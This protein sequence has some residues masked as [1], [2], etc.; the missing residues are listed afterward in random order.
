MPH[1]KLFEH[2]KIKKGAEDCSVEYR[3][4]TAIVRPLYFRRL[5]RFDERYSAKTGKK[6]FK[7]EQDQL[8]TKQWVGVFNVE[9]LSVEI[10]PKIERRTS[11]DGEESDERTDSNF[12]RRNLLKM[13]Q[14]AGEIP[15]RPRGMAN[16][17][18]QR[19]TI[20]EAFIQIFSERLLQE[21]KKGRHKTYVNESANLSKIRGKIDFSRQFTQNVA[22]HDRF[23]VN[24]EDFL[25]DNR[26]NQVFKKVCSSLKQRVRS[27]KTIERLNHILMMLGSVSRR[28]IT[29]QDFKRVHFTRQNDRFEELFN[30]CRLMFMGEAPTTASGET[31]SFALLFDMNHVYES[32]VAEYLRRYVLSRPEFQDWSIDTQSQNIGKYLLRR[33]VD[34][35]K[36]FIL[37]PDIILTESAKEDD[38]A[39]DSARIVIDTKWKRLGTKENG[40]LSNPNRGDLYQLYAY[41]HRYNSSRNILLYP[42]HDR[43]LKSESYIL[44]GTNDG[45][46][47]TKKVQ[48]NFLNMGLDFRREHDRLLNEF[49]RI[50]SP[51]RAS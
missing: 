29:A 50:L 25:P 27:S 36:S 9:G 48:L 17:A 37:R 33:E 2:Q 13:L 42:R 7:W 51:S 34:N 12:A 46:D 31:T 26:L 18:T 47:S 6:L 16:I 22:R 44:P 15:S 1:L 39:V 5:T 35:K 24:Y 40:Q 14:V 45:D 8:R 20:L 41:A 11:T 10:L 21:V 4:D 32:F 38:S 43:D 23:S 19:G 49:A 28:V 30:F 3:D